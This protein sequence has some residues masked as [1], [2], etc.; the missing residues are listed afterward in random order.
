MPAPGEKLGPYELQSQLGRGGMGEVWQARD[1]R[2]NRTVAVKISNAQFSERFEREAHAVAALNHPHVC[3]LYD[4]GPDFLV[5]EYIDG[6]A[7][8]GPMPLDQALDYAIQ[9][10]DALDAAHRKGIVHRDLKPANILVNKSGIKLLDFGLAKIAPPQAAAAGATETI[11]LTQ[12]HAILGTLQYMAPEQLEGRD[13]GARADIFAFGAVLYEML[14]GRRAFEGASKASLIAAIMTR[15]PPSVSTVA[16][17]N[18]DHIVRRCLA[19]DR[20][21][22]GPPLAILPSNSVGFARTAHQLRPLTL[23]NAKPVPASP[24]L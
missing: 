3:Q 6:K 8:A 23:L 24:G 4:V 19:K 21:T 18:I 1:S 7:L 12:E 22:V 11:A 17:A 20:M 15:E 2:L 16:P 10:A 13:A 9:I 5:M 14:T